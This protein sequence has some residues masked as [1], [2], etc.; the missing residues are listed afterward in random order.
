MTDEFTDN[1]PSPLLPLAAGLL[2]GLASGLCVG[3]LLG[4]AVAGRLGG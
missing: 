3:L 2:I 1:T 4:V